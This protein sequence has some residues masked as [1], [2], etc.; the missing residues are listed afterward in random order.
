MDKYVAQLQ[1]DTGA[2][3]ENIVEAA[4]G[5]GGG[6]GNT[7]DMEIN[8][9]L[10]MS[11]GTP[12]IVLDKTFAEIKQVFNTEGRTY[13][14]LMKY[15]P[16]MNQE[17]TPMTCYIASAAASTITFITDIRRVPGHYGITGST[18]VSISWSVIRIAVDNSNHVAYGRSS[19]GF[20]ITGTI[21]DVIA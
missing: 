20:G 8:V 9:S 16:A 1:Q 4:G 3:P 19:S 21:T 12:A 11:G 7:Y 14:A 6:G 10:D 18:N 17:D 15:D 13:T 5:G 2:T